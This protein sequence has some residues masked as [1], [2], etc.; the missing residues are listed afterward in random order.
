[1]RIGIEFIDL[2]PDRAGGV[3]R[4]VTHLVRELV[5]LNSRH[6]FRLFLRDEA[7]SLFPPGGPVSVYCTDDGYPKPLRRLGFLR[8]RWQWLLIHRQR[9]LGKQDVSH[10][11]MHFPRPVWGAKNL[12]LTIHDLLY[13]HPRETFGIFGARTM[14]WHCR[15]GARLARRIIADS[16]FVKNDIVETYRIAPEKIDVVNLGVDRTVFHP[17]PDRERLD[18]FR[19]Q[20]GLPA[21][22]LFF[23]AASFVHKTH[24]CLFQ[25]LALLRDLYRLT[26]PLVLTGSRRRGFAVL[27]RAMRDCK[28][29]DSVLWL[30]YLDLEELVLCYQGAA[31]LVF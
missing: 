6:E 2:I 11:T 1:M 21:D 18:R 13:E 25:A 23:A 8:S 14:G 20:R 26:C 3:E 10:G 27:Q 12:V 29:E 24:R 17:S 4:Y 30:D 28:V 9:G 31:A 5:A 22:Y 19:L 7:R 16:Q 15:T